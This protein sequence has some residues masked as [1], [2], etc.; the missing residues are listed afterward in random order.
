MPTPKTSRTRKL[1]VAAKPAVHNK[2]LSVLYKQPK[3]LSLLSLAHTA[4]LK[5][6][7]TSLAAQGLLL[8]RSIT[9]KALSRHH[10]R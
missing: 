9:K 2:K 3:P 8:R 4:Q 5:K 10:Y 7:D 1:K 6:P